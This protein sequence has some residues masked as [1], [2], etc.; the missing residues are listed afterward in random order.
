MDKKYLVKALEIA[1]ESVESGGYP[2]GAVIVKGNKILGTGS[3]EGSSST[4][5]TLHAE[6]AAI[7]QASKKLNSKDLSGTILY[8]SLEPC[9][10]CWASAFWAKIPRIVYGCRKSKVST[11]LYESRLDLD[12]IN[13]LGLRKIELKFVDDFETESLELIKEFEKKNK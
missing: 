6:T 2:I 5:A 10:M 3:S 1:K 4:D 11:D 13:N 12:M 8:S 7:R 9:L